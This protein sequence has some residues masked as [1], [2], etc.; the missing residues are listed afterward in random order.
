ML[1]LKYFNNIILYFLSIY[2]LEFLFVIGIYYLIQDYFL[3]I[4]S[5]FNEFSIIENSLKE[6]IK[7]YFIFILFV[8]FIL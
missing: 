2:E 6:D 3:I 5:S 7:F 4:M 8:A 1:N